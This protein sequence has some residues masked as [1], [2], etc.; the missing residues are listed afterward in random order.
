VDRDGKLV[1]NF[2][3]AKVPK[4]ENYFTE[5]SSI[6]PGQGGTGGIVGQCFGGTKSFGCDVLCCFCLIIECSNDADNG[7]GEDNTTPSP[8]PSGYTDPG[9]PPKENHTNTPGILDGTSAIRSDVIDVAAD[10]WHHVLISVD[11][12]PLA[13]HGVASGESADGPIGDYIDSA[14]Q[15]FIALDDKNYIKDKLSDDWAEGKG[16]NDVVSDG[17]YEVAG[18]EAGEDEPIPKYTLEDSSV[19]AGPVGLPATTKYVNN[20]YGVQMAEFLM[21][22][23]KTLDTGVEGNRRHFITNVLKDGFQHPTNTQ[24]LYIPFFKYAIGDPATWEP[25]ADDPVYAPPLFDPSAWPTAIKGLG[26]ADIDFTKCQFNWQMGR[27]IGTND[28]HVTKTG[29]IKGLVPPK[30][31]SPKVQPGG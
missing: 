27:N 5:V 10:A 31:E 12:K 17:A 1:V 16:D 13:S 22:T 9:Y 21:W 2:E 8:P 3:S 25:G 15:L 29:K 7:D 4:T 23:G 20:I 19:P 28:S 30:D 24:P 11:L 14:S 6:T 18:E 26:T